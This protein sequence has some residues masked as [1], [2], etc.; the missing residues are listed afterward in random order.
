MSE[1][2][3]GPDW[4]ATVPRPADRRGVNP[5][6]P[7][8]GVCVAIAIALG[9]L[10]WV[11]PTRPASLVCLSVSA[12]PDGTPVPFASADFASISAEPFARP[13][14]A[15]PLDPTRDQLRT[16]LAAMTTHPPDTPL[17]VFLTGAATVV[18][19]S[20]ELA[21]GV[22]GADHAR[23][24]VTLSEVLEQVRAVKASHKLVVLDIHS[25]ASDWVSVAEACL[26]N[27]AD[28]H[29]LVLFSRGSSEQQHACDG[30]VFVRYWTAGVRGAADGWGE[31]GNR[32]GRVSVSELAAFVRARTVR[33]AEQNRTSPQ[34][35]WL[36]GDGSD[37]V[38]AAGTRDPAEAT[39]PA[40]AAKVFEAWAVQDA[41]LSDGRADRAPA[42]FARLQRA[43]KNMERD[44]LA[45][46]SPD[47]A[48][49]AFDA[50]HSRVETDAAAVL[51][52]GVPECLLPLP[53]PDAV[54]VESLRRYLVRTDSIPEPMEKPPAATTPVIL[55]VASADPPLS[56]G[57]L[58]RL[59]RLLSDTDPQTNFAPALL[60][61]RLATENVPADRAARLLRNS[62]E[63]ERIAR[64]VSFFNWA[65]VGLELAFNAWC[66]AV[67]FTCNVGYSNPNDADATL[68]DLEAS[69]RTLAFAADAHATASTTLHRGE[70]VLGKSDRLDQL[71]FALVPPHS[72]PEL[73]ETAIAANAWA[74][75]AG[76][77][78]SEVR[79][80]TAP[81]SSAE[82]AAVRRKAT[83]SDA[84]P[85]ELAELERV[86]KFFLIPAKD[87]A[88]LW[89]VRS[90][91]ARRLNEATAEHDRQD[92]DDFSAGRRTPVWS[93]PRAVPVAR[94]SLPELAPDFPVPTP[95]QFP[96]A[97]FLSWHAGRFDHFSRN[98]LDLSRPTAEI[99][100]AV[101]ALEQCR[102]LGAPSP[103]VI[104]L[105]IQ[106]N[107]ATL[108]PAKP[109]ATVSVG[110]RPV[111]TDQPVSTRVEVLSPSAEWVTTPVAGSLPIT[112]A[113]GLVVDRRLSA[114]RS[115]EK[116]PEL[117]GVLVRC[118]AGGRAFF[119]RVD[120]D[121]GALSGRLDLLLSADPKL[122]P[123][124]ATELRVRPN[125]RP[126]KF[127]LVVSNPTP[128]AQSVIV[129]LENPAR[130]TAALVIPPGQSVPVV[131]PP[132]ALPAPPAP[133]SPVP[134]FSSAPN[135]F[136]VKFLDAKTRQLRQTFT[137]P[138][139]V[140]D[141]AELLDVRDVS[142]SP[143][144]ELKATVGERATF[145]GGDMPVSLT[146]PEDRN[147]GLTVTDGR[148]S[149]A[150]AAGQGTL[151]LYAKKLKFE[152]SAGRSVT[153]AMA[154][155]GVERAFLFT[156]EAT[157][158][159][160][161]RFQPFTVP[162]IG[163]RGD[164][165]A[166]G[167][168]PLAVKLETDN[169]PPTATVELTVESDANTSDFTKR[170]IPAK[171][172]TLAVAFDPKGG[173][174]LTAT[175]SDPEP[176]LPVDRL[177][178]TRVIV[179]RLLDANDV[180]LARARKTVVFDGRRPKGVRFIDP[181]A[182]VAADKPLTVTA[183][184]D[185]PVSGVKEVHFFVGR[186]AN[187]APPPA[188]LL[189]PAKAGAK[190]SWTATV[191]LDGA[192]GPLDVSVRFT[193][194]AGLVAFATVQ[195]E[196]LDAAEI[197]KPE[198]AAVKG[199]VVEGT[200]AQPGLT[201]QLLDDKGKEKATAKTKADGTFAF[202]D[203]PP[204][205]YSLVV[206]KGTTGRAKRLAVE[207][208]PGEE[209]GVELGLLLK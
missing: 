102:Q 198:P 190:N 109:T 154:A 23:N 135:T 16:A 110:V 200:L 22:P 78:E 65:H 159:A 127:A 81:Y 124:A 58:K 114:G 123:S 161:V 139:R 149:G 116:H 86:L 202:A 205:K 115:P 137:L 45:G 103:P 36:T 162:R 150:F 209:K 25:P 51:A 94:G 6:M 193:S 105:E 4:R 31:A 29:R 145:V 201:V 47:E 113:R 197:G 20:V 93:D 48:R 133:S 164:D 184:C 112:P 37:F 203:L 13:S 14:F 42:D 183:T 186:P 111:G 147:R 199:T 195:L 120:V 122:P 17:V 158:G 30:A 131:F 43:L 1:A 40:D 106:A 50:A 56:A 194:K 99:S 32:D 53:A 165:F 179:A 79:A 119:K 174:T 142:Y 208:K 9:L 64:R 168:A 185:L 18:G 72:S 69:L 24:R 182:N 167:T 166:T 91:L 49:R 84:G 68:S 67:A 98:P 41:W 143:A 38:L 66:S 130:E 151:T 146:F 177:V 74:K 87:R 148:L 207:L 175:V 5:V 138:V 89:G 83:G 121:A 57:Q 46:K 126:A 63:F 170:G 153:L 160:A 188:A 70:R 169:A 132:P 178:G 28:S 128:A 44:W 101:R 117:L 141:P 107:G 35:P 180:E 104:H 140:T 2:P 173:L 196:R 157:G 71:R 54:A 3:R 7:L 33:W 171:N 8:V 206:E 152:P 60:L 61:A 19:D 34:T 75:L 155:D 97:A 52:A 92:D 12:S 192:K 95:A 129:Q 27:V 59:A 15:L 55:A 108:T 136:V 85:R 77:V 189:V 80:A 144:G 163:I 187:D 26:K 90:A 62:L 204:G 10:L 181:P 96:R 125:G 76:E 73:G 82:L 172:R 156:G 11:Q 118:E 100:F 191:P 39:E 88:E 21:A 134:E 176:Q